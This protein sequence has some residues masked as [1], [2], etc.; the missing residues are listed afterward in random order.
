M[1]GSDRAPCFPDRLR[2]QPRCARRLRRAGVRICSDELN[3]ASIIDGARLSRA[4]VAVYRHGDVDHLDALLGGARAPPSSSPTSCSPWTATSLPCAERRRLLPPAR[5]SARPRRGPRRAR[6]RPRPRT[7]PAPTSCGWGPC[8]RPSGPSAASWPARARSIDLLVNRARSYIFTTALTPAD[9]AAALAALRVL[10]SAE[11]E[12]P[13]RPAGRPTSTLWP[14]AIPVPSSPSS[15]GSDE[16]AV[17]ASAALRRPRR[18]GA[19]HPAAHR[20]PGTAR[21]PRHPVGRPY[22]RAHR[23]APGGARRRCTGRV[24]TVAVSGTRPAVVVLVAGTGTDVGKTWVS[25]RLLEAWRRRRDCGGGPQAGPVLRRRL[26][27]DRRRGPG[28]GDAARTRPPSARRG[29]GTRWPWPRPWPRTSSAW[30]RPTVADLVGEL[31]W[32]SRAVDVGLVETAGGVRVPPGRRRRRPRPGRGPRHRPR[33]P[34]GRRR[35]RHHQR[36]APQHGA[37]L[38]EALHT[39]VVALNRYDPSSDLH[40]RQPGLAPRRRR[41]RRSR[42]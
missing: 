2:R 35:T 26:G 39:A 20:A 17:A 36:R 40:R 37:A 16:R 32:P 12:R 33:R 38:V 11:G 15:S 25:A 24:S 42:R 10:P 3:H 27:P 1:E 22:R 28:G 30:P 5:R 4:E 14:P 21:L 9:A 19:G 31:A 18:L 7:S 8:P 34:G 41:H 13:A 23:P 6:P 29:V